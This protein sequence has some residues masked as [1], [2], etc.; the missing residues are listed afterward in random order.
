MERAGVAGRVLR[1]RNGKGRQ[2]RSLTF[3]SFR[4]TAASAVFNS[5]AIREVARR[6]SNHARGGALERYLHQDLAPIREATKL[7]P[8]LPRVAE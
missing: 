7:I 6:V 2:V 3:H 5:E 8:R 4:H 1:E